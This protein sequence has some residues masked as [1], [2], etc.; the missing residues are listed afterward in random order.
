M[1]VI[2][3][4]KLASH[5]LSPRYSIIVGASLIFSLAE[6]H[7]AKFNISFFMGLVL[8]YFIVAEILDRGLQTQKNIL[9]PLIWGAIFNLHGVVAFA[10]VPILLMVLLINVPPKKWSIFA[11]L[12]WI[13]LFIASSQPLIFSQ[14]ARLSVG[15]V[16]PIIES[17]QSGTDKPP[18][19]SANNPSSPTEEWVD[20]YTSQVR[21]AFTTFP[22]QAADF[23]GNYSSIVLIFSLIGLTMLA[24]NPTPPTTAKRSIL[25]LGVSLFLLTQ[26]AFLGLQWFS[27]RFLLGLGPIITILAVYALDRFGRLLKDDGPAYYAA[28]ACITMPG[29]LTTL[30][31]ISQLTANIAP[32]NYQFIHQVKSVLPPNA[33]VFVAGG[34]GRWMQGL[35]PSSYV[36][37]THPA[38]I[39]SD[40]SILNTISDELWQASQAFSHNVNSSQSIALFKK[41]IGQQPYYVYLDPANYHCINGS[42]FPAP[43]YSQVARQG[44]LILL[45]HE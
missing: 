31:K 18:S 39:C 20:E 14:G 38:A 19:S 44:E 21:P 26:Q 3:G 11:C 24:L 27:N 42:L 43:D 4:T 41:L 30:P 16:K 32:Q 22:L 33:P 12:T 15:L 5:I 8:L 10:S 37:L 1:F 13:F 36:L 40:R 2:I 25:V 17:I 9:I 34:D 6:F 7:L 35:I 23:I 28:I 29:L 45:R